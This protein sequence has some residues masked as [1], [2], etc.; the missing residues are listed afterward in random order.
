MVIEKARFLKVSHHF[1]RL[2]LVLDEL[3]ELVSLLLGASLLLLQLLANL[4]P[5]LFVKLIN[6][7]ADSLELPLLTSSDFNHGVKKLTVVNFNNEI[8]H[9][10][11]SQNVSDDSKHFS[12]WDHRRVGSSDIEITLVELSESTL[13]HLGL[14]TTV[15]LS[16]HESL[17][18]RET[19]FSNISGE[20]DSQVIT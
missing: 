8:S 11:A 6:G 15:D 10:Q 19:V 9:V 5:G 4:R 18:A 16:N 13:L 2:S 20:G 14:V 12:V 17:D 7:R 1:P 3:T